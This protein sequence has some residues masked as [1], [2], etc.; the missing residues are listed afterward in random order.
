MDTQRRKSIRQPARLLAL[1]CAFG[2]VVAGCA[3]LPPPT[4]GEYWPTHGWRTS[5]PEAQ[6][7]DS[8]KLAQMLE[9]IRQEPKLNPHSLLV[10]RHGYLV[11][12]VYFNPMYGPDTQHVLYSVTKS[13]ISTLVGIAFDKG[14]LTDLRRPVLSF[15][16]RRTIENRDALKESMT[17]E[18]LLTMQSGLD[19]VDDMNSVGEVLQTPDAVQYVLSLPMKEAPGTRFNYCSGCSHV[20]SGILQEQ[21]GVKILDFAKQN[22]FGPLGISDFKWETDRQGLPLGGWGLYLTPR[23]MAK[24]GYLYLHD[25]VWD[26]KQIVSAAWVKAATQTRTDPHHK[27][28]FGY[29]YQWWT[30][31][32]LGAYQAM[33]QYGQFIVVVPASDLVVVFTAEQGDL[34]NEADFKL[35]ESYILTAVKSPGPL[36]PNAAGQSELTAQTKASLRVP[37][38]SQLNPSAVRATAEQWSALL[39]ASFGLWALASKRIYLGGGEVAGWPARVVGLLALGVV[40]LQITHH[41]TCSLLVSSDYSPDLGAQILSVV[42]ILGGWQAGR[43]VTAPPPAPRRITAAWVFLACGAAAGCLAGVALQSPSLFTLP[44]L[45]A[46]APPLL[47]CLGLAVTAVALLHYSNAGPMA[48]SWPAALTGGLLVGWLFGY[49]G[50]GILNALGSVGAWLAALVRVGPAGLLAALVAPWPGGAALAQAV[51]QGVVLLLAAFGVWV[52]VSRSVY[53]GGGRAI[54][55]WAAIGLGLLVLATAVARSAT[56]P[57]TGMAAYVVSRCFGPDLMAYLMSLGIIFGGLLARRIPPEALGPA[58]A[59]FVR[60]GWVPTALSLAAGCLL[61]VTLKDPVL[62]SGATPWLAVR[63]GLTAL[64]LAG[65]PLVILAKVSPAPRTVSLVRIVAGGLLLGLMLGYLSG[66]IVSAVW[67]IGVAFTTAGG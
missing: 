7:M 2:L 39:L 67:P 49:L 55:G 44:T 24:L 3:W 52:L 37:P 33:G 45:K 25:G 28:G 64:G 32:R 62:L 15:F 29:G 40:V 6:G 50:Q 19:W 8:V 65:V 43:A 5:T 11:S 54:T 51:N 16:P 10:I 56:R 9:V 23:D 53:L 46:W 38:P 42:A 41:S 35:I 17:L 18:D 61:G 13:F 26:G 66:G 4:T 22:L 1:L 31:P 21:P 58:P 14:I 48:E 12:E 34:A 57:Y 63:L 60:A 20:L 47:V 59:R 27:L 36:P 30:F